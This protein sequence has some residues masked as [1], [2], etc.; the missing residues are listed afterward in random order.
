MSKSP[1]VAPVLG[2]V[3]VRSDAANRGKDRRVRVEAVHGA[4]DLNTA[5]VAYRDP[6]GRRA[7]MPLCSFLQPARFLP[8]AEE[9][10]E[11]GAT[12]VVLRPGEAPTDAEAHTAAAELRDAAADVYDQ[13]ATDGHLLRGAGMLARLGRALGKQSADNAERYELASALVMLGAEPRAMVFFDRR[14][15]GGAAAWGLTAMFAEM[16]IES[17][18]A[19]VLRAVRAKAAGRP[20]S[21]E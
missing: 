12:I 17:L 13:L 14:S 3:W 20:V 19:I 18:R 21:A 10:R 7:T 11:E 16:R 6:N 2:S 8:C 15:E 1:L 5:I 4:E 9:T